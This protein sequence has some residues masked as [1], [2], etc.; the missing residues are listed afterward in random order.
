M[1]AT[2]FSTAGVEDQWREVADPWLRQHALAWKSQLPTVILTPSRAESFYLRS[3][4]VAESVPY[5]G[6]R[7]WTPSDARQFLLMALRPAVGPGT[8]AEWRLLARA[9]AE[10]LAA[11]KTRDHASI[12]SVARDPA[13]FLRAYDLL[14]GAGWDPAVDGVAYGQALAKEFQRALKQH[15]IST[16]AGIHRELRR[17]ALKRQPKL[18]AGLLVTGFNAT[19]WP[20]WDLLKAVV[21]CAEDAVVS[22]QNPREFAGNVDQLW[23]GSW[24]QFIGTGAEVPDAMAGQE[25]AAPFA[26]LAL[27][28][29]RGTGVPRSSL[30]DLTFLVT[31]DLASQSRA[32]VLQALEYLRRDDCTRL[33]IVCPSANALAL[34]VAGEL[35]RLGIPLDDGTGAWMPGPFEQHCWQTW[36]TLQEEPGVPN[37]IAWARACTAQGVSCGLPESL[38]ARDLASRLDAALSETLVD[39]LDFLARHLEQDQRIQESPAA[40]EFLRARIALPESATFA[41]YLELT[42]RVAARLDWDEH[43]ARLEAEPPPWLMRNRQLLPRRIFIE[44]L[45][46]AMAS[47]TRTRGAEGNHFYGRV[48]LVIYAQMT[49]QTWSHLILTGLNEGVWPRLHEPGAFGSRHELARLNA[50]IKELNPQA[51]GEGRFGAGHETVG[52]EHGHCLLPLEQQAIALRDMCA[53]IES[54]S[55][56]LS[57]TALATEAGRSLLP[58]DFFN[59]AWQLQNGRILSDEDF[60]SLANATEAWCRRHPAVFAHESEA[61]PREI[62]LTRI[63]YA[64]RRNASTPFGVYEFSHAQPPAPPVQLTCKQW[65]DAWRH[66]ATVWLSRIVG[67]TA[68]PEGEGSWAN[69]IGM[70]V[71][72]W[73]ALGLREWRDRHHGETE[74]PVLVRAAADREAAT[75][76]AH[77]GEEDVALYP[78]WEQVWMQARTRAVQLAESLAPALPDHEFLSE[79]SLPD[80]LIIALPGSP[81]ADFQL[82]GRIDFLRIDR[83]DAMHDPGHPD[84]RNCDGWVIDFKTGAAKK[85]TVEQ[86]LKGS[87][88]QAVLYALAVRSLGAESVAI[89]LLAPGS[90]LKA[91]LQ[92]APDLDPILASLDTLHRRGIFGMRADANS[93]YGFNPAYPIATQFV[94]GYILDAKWALT[95]GVAGEDEP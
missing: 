49:G 92:L 36:L 57:L 63:A 48:H 86:A 6:L 55:A 62:E 46:D 87:G 59:H 16:Q 34:S 15:G 47:Q 3:R 45:R 32:V 29:E 13:A 80:D 73:L 89:S 77:A 83:G 35:R 66:P 78:W 93:D 39:D 95:H 11:K 27:S 64:A 58:S 79:F 31:P 28:Y 88:L 50:R 60:R 10:K 43:L 18:I 41:D 9:C 20:L 8:Q 75:I 30:A 42:R 44:W 21:A 37:L 68:W 17:L 24:E 23:H 70:W 91:Q 84:F 67:A 14:L 61:D 85:L 69:A 74:F 19:H 1:A 40:A 22:L 56:A 26:D 94:P 51:E 71:H 5:L 4:L 54:T 25:T 12:T 33:G 38:T 53:A 82:K 2:L 7:F 52:L 72:R 81:R 76:R 90:E 65:E